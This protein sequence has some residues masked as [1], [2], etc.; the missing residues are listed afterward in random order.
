MKPYCA[1]IFCKLLSLQFTI[2]VL[3]QS[4]CNDII[5]LKNSNTN[6]GSALG[7]SCN[8]KREAMN[9]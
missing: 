6:N 5:I 9:I 1:V 3:I 4:I 7:I 8:L 2:P